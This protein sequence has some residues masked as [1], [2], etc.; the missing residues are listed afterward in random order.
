MNEA[1]DAA[2]VALVDEQAWLVGGAVRDRLLGR[3]VTDI[4]IAVAG[5]P[6]AA[7]RRV[8]VEAGGPAFELS[9]QFG[10]WRVASR[11]GRWQIDVMTLQGG[12]IEEDL[13]RR[14]F[15]INAMAEPL[16]GG[17]LLDPHD[18]VA[19]LERR[20]LRVVAPR[21]FD[22]DPLRVLR[23]ARFACELGLQAD[24]ETVAQARERADR[25]P[26]VAGE[27]IFAELRRVVGADA[28]IAGL[29]LMESLGLTASLLPEF[30]ALRG[31]E[32]NRYHHLDVLSHTLAVLENVVAMQADPG[33]VLGDEFAAPVKAWLAQPFADELT[34]GT[35][36]RFG[37]MFHDIA[38]PATQAH[39]DDGTVLGFPGHA[40]EGARVSRA[41]LARCKT[42]ERLRAHVAALA[43][44][45]LDAGYLVSDEPLSRRAIHRY[46]MAS[47]DV[48]VDV[49]LLSIADRLATRGR[50][51]DA[52]IT[53]HLEV[54]R[55]LLGAAIEYQ[56]AG[57]AP[58]LIRGDDLA[59]ELGIAL[60]PEV[61]RL[62]A[63]LAEA[64]YADEIRTRD[65]AIAYA[66]GLLG[67]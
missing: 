14:D 54:A 11:D 58:A 62:L 34:R 52:A 21:A 57:P 22:D 64:Q 63:A 6:R 56:E 60:G 16:G 24:P 20:L 8:S 36:L 41:I 3:E 17:P 13:A 49:T 35:A 4:D 26:A 45:H 65:D 46:L 53:K 47:G 7:A 67:A 33:A 27:R 61:G 38:K 30:A 15:T 59:A 10:A 29:E 51:A 42:S 43:R 37:A 28:V 39:H 1:L 66:R 55:T 25:V 2:R 5:D 19:D 40:D 23:L 18:G 48:A 12:S 50:N 31:V 44:H 32:Q 9:D